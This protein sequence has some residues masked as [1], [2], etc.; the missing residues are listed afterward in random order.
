LYEGSFTEWQAKGAEIERVPPL[1]AVSKDAAASDAV[2]PA[3]AEPELPKS[4]DNKDKD[5]KKESSTVKEDQDGEDADAR[6]ERDRY[7]P[8]T[9]PADLSGILPNRGAI[10][11]N[12]AARPSNLPRQRDYFTIKGDYCCSYSLIHSPFCDQESVKK[13]ICVMNPEQC[14]ILT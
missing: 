14:N 12:P 8:Q 2:K 9:R 13:A 5:E 4:E 3:T 10:D 6:R 1:P 11:S 7:K